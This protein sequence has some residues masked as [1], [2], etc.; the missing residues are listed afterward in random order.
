METMNA[1]SSRYSVSIPNR[2]RAIFREMARRMGWETKRIRNIKEEEIYEPNATTLSA[3]QAVRAGKV[4]KA[5]SAEDLINQI[6]G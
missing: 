4:Y 5:S 6:L 2:D 1:A 3:M